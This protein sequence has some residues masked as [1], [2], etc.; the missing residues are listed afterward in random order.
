[1][2]TN[3]PTPVGDAARTSDAPV[4]V[5][6]ED[7]RSPFASY[8][9]VGNKLQGLTHQ[10]PTTNNPTGAPVAYG[11]ASAVRASG[12]DLRRTSARLVS[13]WEKTGNAIAG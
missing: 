3:K 12:C 13:P 10:Q 5:A 11:G 7:R 4:F 9:G 2:P 1:M 6:N 8:L